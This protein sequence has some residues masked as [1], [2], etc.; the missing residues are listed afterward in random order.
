MTY[1][2]MKFG[3]VRRLADSSD[4]PAQAPGNRDWEAYQAWLAL[5]NTPEPMDSDPVPPAPEDL[6]DQ[7]QKLSPARRAALKALLAAS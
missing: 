3:M 1:K 4:F 2:L 7:F 5:G 6:V